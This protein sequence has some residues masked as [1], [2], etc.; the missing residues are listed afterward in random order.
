MNKPI[1]ELQN[2]PI[3]RYGFTMFNQNASHLD[4]KRTDL[5]KDLNNATQNALKLLQDESGGFMNKS[6]KIVNQILNKIKVFQKKGESKNLITY[7]K[8]Q[9]L[10]KSYE[11]TPDNWFKVIK[12]FLEIWNTK[13]GLNLEQIPC[14]NINSFKSIFVNFKKAES[15]LIFMK[16]LQV[17]VNGQ[18]TLL[19][20]VPTNSQY[21]NYSDAEKLS[22]KQI[23]NLLAMLVGVG[24]K[25]PGK[26]EGIINWINNVNTTTVANYD[27]N[28]INNI[29]KKWVQGC[30]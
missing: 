21:L 12:K 20:D 2:N 4:K 9:Q 19:A 15:L 1:Q 27:K 7:I 25:S 29:L 8:F 13:N 22:R 5:L 24:R 16:I 3:Y 28:L 17:N 14:N 26:S 18:W 10:L 6:I 23:L 11:I 30:V